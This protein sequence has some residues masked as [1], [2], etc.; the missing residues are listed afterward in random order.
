MYIKSF[1]A[2]TEKV[3]ESSELQE[4]M[5]VLEEKYGHQAPD[6]ENADEM[7]FRELIALANQYGFKFTLNDIY[8]YFMEKGRDYSR[9]LTEEELDKIIG[10]GPTC[11][12]D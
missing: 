5:A 4:K 11:T 2:F 12:F 9:E 6:Q 8:L 3:H 1:R 10:G 7:F